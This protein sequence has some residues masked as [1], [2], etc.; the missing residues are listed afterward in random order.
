M[1]IYLV[2][3]LKNGPAFLT[4]VAPVEAHTTLKAA[5][6]RMKELD[7]KSLRKIFYIKAVELT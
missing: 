2:M 1:K 6:L 4:V 3:Y 5:K 7:K